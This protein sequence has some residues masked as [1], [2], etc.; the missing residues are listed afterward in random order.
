MVYVYHDSCTST[1][2]QLSTNNKSPLGLACA[3]STSAA[4]ADTGLGNVVVFTLRLPCQVRTVFPF[5]CDRIPY[6][7]RFFLVVTSHS[8]ERRREDATVINC[9]GDRS[10]AP[11]TNTRDQIPCILYFLVVIMSHSLDDVVRRLPSQQLLLT[12]DD[13]RG[14]RLTIVSLGGGHQE[15]VKKARK[16]WTMTP[17]S[18]QQ[19]SKSSAKTFLFIL[20]ASFFT[21]VL[22]VCVCS[23]PALLLLSLAQRR[24]K[25]PSSIIITSFS[26]GN[27]KC[28]AARRERRKTFDHGNFFD[29]LG[30]G[31]LFERTTTTTTKARERERERITP[32]PQIERA[33]H[34]P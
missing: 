30:I 32:A 1:Q 12:N 14:R 18:R 33:A 25:F 5:P 2:A 10:R 15:E 24:K 13:W 11:V 27:F 16:L 17:A 21:C 19:S 34:P 7:L 29:L 8:F 26:A 23:P 6:I 4:E 28:P 3:S 9:C 20:L 22:C 31:K